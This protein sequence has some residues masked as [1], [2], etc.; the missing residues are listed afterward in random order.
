MATNPIYEGKLRSL[1]SHVKADRHPAHA[2]QKFMCF[3]REIAF[4]DRY[5]RNREAE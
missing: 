2:E 3:A 4:R 1:A 5:A